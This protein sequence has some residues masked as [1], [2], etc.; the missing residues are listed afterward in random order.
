[1]HTPPSAKIEPPAARSEALRAEASTPVGS[2]ASPEAVKLDV[3]PQAA[4]VEA[5]KPPARARPRAVVARSRF[6]P[7][8]RQAAERES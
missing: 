5:E 6:H 2:M 1:M 8:G 7:P 3:A 4:K